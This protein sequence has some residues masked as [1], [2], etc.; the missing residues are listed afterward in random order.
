[1]KIIKNQ[2]VIIPSLW[3]TSIGET[4]RS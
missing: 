3:K 4:M 2:L 1:M